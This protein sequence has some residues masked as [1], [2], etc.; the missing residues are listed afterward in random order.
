MQVLQ[1]PPDELMRWPLRLQWAPPLQ[2]Q[3]RMLHL[4]R[5]Q[6]QRLGQQRGAAGLALALQLV[7]QLVQVLHRFGLGLMQLLCLPL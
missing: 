5:M 2:P 3:G 1:A 7:A 6:R 4:R